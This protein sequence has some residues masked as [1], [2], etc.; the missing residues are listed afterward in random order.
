MTLP[1]AQ[2]PQQHRLVED[3][4]QPGRVRAVQQLCAPHPQIDPALNLRGRRVRQPALH[5]G[6]RVRRGLQQAGDV[7]DLERT[8]RGRRFLEADQP[9]EPFR[10]QPFVVPLPPAGFTRALEQP[11]QH[12]RLV[13]TGAVQ[14]EQLADVVLGRR[15]PALAGLDP[16]Q[17]RPAE[18]DR[19]GRLVLGEARVLTEARELNAHQHLQ[20]SGSG[21]GPV[22]IG[23]QPGGTG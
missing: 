23:F 6:T 13:L 11:Q 20:E 21:L 15:A 7:L 5:H 14:I 22:Q 19:A 8:D 16:G 9:F 10:H 1:A 12:R 4:P 2:H 18:T 3:G 17:F